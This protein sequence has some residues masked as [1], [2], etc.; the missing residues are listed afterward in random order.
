MYEIL[1]GL[2]MISL[3]NETWDFTIFSQDLLFKEQSQK[4]VENGFLWLVRNVLRDSFWT[5]K[6]SKGC[7]YLLYPYN[8]NKQT[9]SLYLSKIKFKSKSIPVL[10]IPVLIPLQFW[11]TTENVNE[12]RRKSS[13]IQ[14]SEFSIS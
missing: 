13:Q 14:A 9:E 6:I 4:E 3:V 1:K 10:F 5:C 2:P 11:I 8:P 7:N 12:V